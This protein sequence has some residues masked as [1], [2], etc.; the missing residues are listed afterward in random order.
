M[1]R[2]VERQRRR[3]PVAILGQGTFSNLT[4]GLMELHFL[5][6]HSFLDVQPIFKPFGLLK[7]P[8]MQL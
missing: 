6:K 2:R 5:N 3:H 8:E 7:T 4:L 1:P